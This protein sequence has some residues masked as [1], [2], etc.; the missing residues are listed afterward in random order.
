[1]SGSLVTATHEQLKHQAKGLTEYMSIKKRQ[2]KI[3]LSQAFIITFQLGRMKDWGM[4]DRRVGKTGR[5]WGCGR[6]V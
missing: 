6:H 3:K 5:R 4:K 2:T 1:M